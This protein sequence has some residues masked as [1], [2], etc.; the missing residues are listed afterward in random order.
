KNLLDRFV[1]DY[2]HALNHGERRASADEI[3]RLQGRVENVLS[4]MNE[5]F[6]QGDPLLAGIGWVTL[7]FHVFRLGGHHSPG[8]SRD[9]LE[10][11]VD[12]VTQTRRRIAAIA[13]GEAPEHVGEREQRLARFDRFRQSPND[14]SAL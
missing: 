12:A 4:A 9:V 7:Y 6:Y 1:R 5:S 8:F 10:D 14:G 13:G 2:R 11:F 3:D